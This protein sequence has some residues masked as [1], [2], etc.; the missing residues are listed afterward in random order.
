MASPYDLLERLLA[1]VPGLTRPVAESVLYDVVVDFVATTAMWVEELPPL[2]LVEG[3]DRYVLVADEP[4]AV[5]VEPLRVE[6][7]GAVEPRVPRSWL[8][9]LSGARGWYWSPTKELWLAPTPT[10][11]VD[12]GIRAVGALAPARLDVD[13]PGLEAW[14]SSLLSGAI[15]RLYERLPNL[16]GARLDVWQYHARRY[17]ADRIRAQ[18]T[19]DG[20]R[21]GVALN[22]FGGWA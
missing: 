14:E 21:N 9:Q 16:P 7:L 1:A 15:A 12:D 6:V 18:V 17:A 10:Q 22:V 2:D 8:L 5:L 20:L 13:V 3:V 4:D 19:A 11:T